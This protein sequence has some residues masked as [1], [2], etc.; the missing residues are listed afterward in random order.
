MKHYPG[1]FLGTPSPL[2]QGEYTFH[3]LGE[4][5]DWIDPNET[6]LASGTFKVNELGQ[7]F[8]KGSE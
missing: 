2:V 8:G 4:L 1:E 3:W 6:L 7:I 5:G